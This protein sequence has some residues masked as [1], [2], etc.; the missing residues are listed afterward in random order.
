MHGQIDVPS[1]LMQ[2]LGAWSAIDRRRRIQPPASWPGLASVRGE[3]SAQW[4][5]SEPTFGRDSGVY[6]IARRARWPNVGAAA[7]N[8]RTAPEAH[9]SS[10]R[11]RRARTVPAASW[12]AVKQSRDW[13]FLGLGKDVK[14]KCENAAGTAVNVKPASCHK[15]VVMR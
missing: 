6:A 14:M 8:R 5:P 15:G 2:N 4:L 7:R 12:S 9:M 1:N 3:C 10:R 13:K 11:L